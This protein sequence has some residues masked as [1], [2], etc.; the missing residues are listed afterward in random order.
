M[1]E[2]QLPELHVLISYET[3]VAFH[4]LVTNICYITKKQWSHT[5]SRHISHWLMY[6]TREHNGSLVEKIDQSS[7]DKMYD[8]IQLGSIYIIDQQDRFGDLIID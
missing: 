4:D 8:K 7:L 3:P 6:R 2:L 5:T 1:L